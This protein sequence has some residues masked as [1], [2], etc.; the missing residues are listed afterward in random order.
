MI[1]MHATQYHGRTCYIHWRSFALSSVLISSL[2]TATQKE[3]IF[4]SSRLFHY[5][6]QSRVCSTCSCLPILCRRPLHP[7]DYAQKNAKKQVTKEL[8]SG[9]RNASLPEHAN[10]LTSGGTNCHVIVLSTVVSIKPSISDH[11][12]LSLGFRFG[13]IALKHS[14]ASSVLHLCMLSSFVY[15]W[16]LKAALQRLSV[17]I[18]WF[19]LLHIHFSKSYSLWIDYAIISYAM[20]P[21]K[22]SLI[23]NI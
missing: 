3:K 20:W 12:S 17:N 11:G 1:L 6:E 18:D 9:E 22:D 19:T 13:Y 4:L 23:V 16:R 5:W 14:L 7:Y 15:W 8:S 2:T 10:W 21:S